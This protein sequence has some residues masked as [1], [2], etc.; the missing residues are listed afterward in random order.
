MIQTI[1]RG[2]LNV[3]HDLTHAEDLSWYNLDHIRFE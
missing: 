1:C 2:T 3:E